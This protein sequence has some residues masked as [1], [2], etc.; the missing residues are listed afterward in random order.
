MKYA[1]NSKDCPGLHGKPKIFI[2]QAFQGSKRQW[3]SRLAEL[4]LQQQQEA[5][6]TSGGEED[7]N[8]PSLQSAESSPIKEDETATEFSL[9]KPAGFSFNH[10]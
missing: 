7:L 9:K 5:E 4:H 8:I 2:V 10:F 3:N 1:F 6:N